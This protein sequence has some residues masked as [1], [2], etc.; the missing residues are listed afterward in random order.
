MFSKLEEHNILL[1]GKIIVGQKLSFWLL[2]CI[3]FYKN[4]TEKINLTMEEEKWQ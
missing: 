4:I 1:I 2:L 3:Q